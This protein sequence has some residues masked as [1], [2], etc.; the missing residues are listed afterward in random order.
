[1]LE[2]PQDLK[3]QN[4]ALR[5]KA[6]PIMSTLN[7]G[8]QLKA[9]HQKTQD[10]INSACIEMC[11]WVYEST[12]QY[13]KQ[14]KLVGIIGGDHSVPYGAI[15]AIGEHLK[16]NFG[17]LH[18]DAHLDLR[19]AYHGFKHSH[20]SIMHNVSQLKQKPK[21]I[22][23]FGIRDFCKEEFDLVKSNPN[24]YNCYF[25]IETKQRQLQ[26]ESWAQICQE[27]ITKMPENIYVSFDIDG[28]TPT[29]CPD[30]GTPVPGGLEFQ[31][32]LM[33]LSTLHKLKKRIVGFDLVEV[34]GGPNNNEWNGNVGART[35]FKL[36]AWSVLT[37][38]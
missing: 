35:L 18:I 25:D 14:N 13:L 4:K 6:L 38:K 30:T 10:E 9:S 24:L 3:D 19:K 5:K 1:M 8:G 20:A 23:Q 37:N 7:E 12:A 31:E 27:A 11:D 26:G 34:S 21:N 15:K 36:C 29:L 28:L 22:T 33:L 16:G 2:I 17:I 32:M